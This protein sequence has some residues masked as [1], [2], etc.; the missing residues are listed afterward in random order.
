M[1]A[2]AKVCSH[3]DYLIL[4]R[5]GGRGC[6]LVNSW[7]FESE[8]LNG[9]TVSWTSSRQKGARSGGSYWF[10]YHRNAL[11]VRFWHETRGMRT[12][13]S[14]LQRGTCDISPRIRSNGRLCCAPHT[15][16]HIIIYHFSTREY[17]NTRSAFLDLLV[18]GMILWN[19]LQHQMKGVYW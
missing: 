1:L 11:E 10:G 14:R 17:N 19:F 2:A 3:R 12:T 5:C 18:Q 15:L 7:I 13:Y 16:R 8:T 6:A 4:K 9:T